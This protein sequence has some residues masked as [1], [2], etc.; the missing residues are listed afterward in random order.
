MD[1]RRGAVCVARYKEGKGKRRKRMEK[2]TVELGRRCQPVVS[3]FSEILMSCVFAQLAQN[4]VVDVLK[5]HDRR[6]V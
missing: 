4:S 1:I 6:V 5:R 2:G 3:P